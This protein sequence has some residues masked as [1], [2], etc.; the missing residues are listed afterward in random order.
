M[1]NEFLQ[2]LQLL[3]VFTTAG[4]YRIGCN[5]KKLEN[6]ENSEILEKKNHSE[7]AR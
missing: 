3:Q 1:L 5:T 6:M 4:G 7:A 2:F